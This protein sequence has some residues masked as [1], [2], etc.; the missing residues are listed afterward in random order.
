MKT[1]KQHFVFSNWSKY[2]SV[3]QFLIR[4]LAVPIFLFSLFIPRSRKIWVFGAW[5]GKRYAD[6]SR[7][8]FEYVAQNIEDVVPIW[9]A[10]SPAVAKRARACGGKSFSKNSF[11]GFWFTSRAGIVV[12]SNGISDVNQYASYGAACVHLWHGVPIKK[13]ELDS[14]LPEP[15]HFL[16]QLKRFVGNYVFRNK[17]LFPYLKTEWNIVLATSKAVQAH[18][19]SA[20][21]VGEER[22]PVLGYP[23]NDR[24]YDL[25]RSRDFAS[26][27]PGS[28]AIKIL[29]A[30]TFRSRFA[31]NFELFADLDVERLAGLLETH[32]ADFYLKLHP[33]IASDE[34]MARYFEKV[35]RLY[36]LSDEF[37]DELND[38]LPSIDV[39]ISDYSGA[40]IDYLLADKPFLLARFDH[41]DYLE[42]ERGVYEDIDAALSEAVSY[43]WED[44][45]ES[46]KEILEGNDQLEGQRI[47]QKSF[48]H[49]YDDAQ[50]AERVAKYLLKL[51]NRKEYASD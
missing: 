4:L 32:N 19:M 38:F 29:Y 44:V 13:I 2:V 18:M 43:T 7:H 40:I 46:L 34:S 10:S 20:F 17:W 35:D 15:E 26:R 14:S 11:L 24:F 21:D 12:C 16:G 31:V 37:C 5:E 51:N 39:L 49:A 27:M 1:R 9:I 22:V 6:N 48:F 45:L 30:P 41:N 36:F 3:G 25:E 47:E 42:H 8:V 28:G 33:I 50:S 23:R